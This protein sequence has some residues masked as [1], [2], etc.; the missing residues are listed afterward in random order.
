LRAIKQFSGWL[1]RTR[2]VAT[3]PLSELKMLNAD[4]DR[5][6]LRRPLAPEELTR[7]VNAAQQG[8]P[9]EGIS[10]SDRAMMYLLAAWTG[11]RKGEIGSLTA[12][13]F[14]LAGDPPTVVVEAQ[15]SKRRR[16]DVQVLHPDLAGK[17]SE[18]LATKKL[19][20]NGLLFPV[21]KRAGGTQRK[22]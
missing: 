13:S 3:D 10:G 11:Y 8:A 15:Y 20:E 4:T 5:R 21:T 6:H 16:R 9:V 22:T 18:W 12:S 2:R 17:I 1:A 7:L 14:D 19:P